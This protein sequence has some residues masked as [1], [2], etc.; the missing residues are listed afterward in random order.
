MLAILGI[1]AIGVIISLFEIP[2]LIKKKWWKEIIVYFLLLS[3]GLFFS[4]LLSLNIAIP[5]PIDFISKI[6]SPVTNFI[7]RMLS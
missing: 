5:T 6:Y 1:L 4:V 2:P 7:E 3:A